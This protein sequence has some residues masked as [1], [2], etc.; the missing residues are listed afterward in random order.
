MPRVPRVSCVPCACGECQVCRLCRVRLVR[1]PCIFYLLSLFYIATL[2][3]Y[4]PMKK[5]IVQNNVAMETK[6]KEREKSSGHGTG[7]Q[8]ALRL[9][10]SGICGI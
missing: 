2:K 9:R 7:S 8:S 4:N 6:L 3:N 10:K 5:Y 1:M